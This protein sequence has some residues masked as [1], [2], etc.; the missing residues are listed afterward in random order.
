MIMTIKLNMP[1][2]IP[3]YH[4]S[5]MQAIKSKI[6]LITTDNILRC[7]KLAAHIGLSVQL[8]FF[9]VLYKSKKAMKIS[10]KMIVYMKNKL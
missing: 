5:K 8:L 10:S 2:V 9:D 6:V 1:D 4:T 7:S 3:L